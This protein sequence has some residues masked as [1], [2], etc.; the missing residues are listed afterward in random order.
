MKKEHH[1][2]I[3]EKVQPYQ[4]SVGAVVLN[5]NGEVLCHHFSGIRG[6]LD[7]YSLMRQT[8]EPGKSLEEMVFFGLRKEFGVRAKIESFLGSIVGEFTNWEQAVI[9][10]T[11][12]YFLCEYEGK[13]EN[14][15]GKGD[16]LE[17]IQSAVEWIKLDDLIAKMKSQAISFGRTDYDESSVLE[18]V[19]SSI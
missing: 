2:F 12:L 3:G 18:K 9:K 10:K 7:I 6:S 17:G 11:T 13:L 16:D 8:V 14:F 1:Y 15:P 5:G 4:L 19:K